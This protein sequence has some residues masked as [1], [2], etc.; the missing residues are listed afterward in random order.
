MFGSLQMLKEQFP[1]P[2]K[3]TN[4]QQRAL[5]PPADGPGG[6]DSGSYH[7]ASFIHPD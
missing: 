1:E 5:S 2:F 3:L 6:G 7:Q 4:Q